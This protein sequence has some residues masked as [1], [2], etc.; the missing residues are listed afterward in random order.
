M[1][2]RGGDGAGVVEQVNR[3][4]KG[5]VGFFAA[6]KARG[7]EEDYGV[8]NAFAAETR[9]RLGVFSKDTDQAAVG[10]VE[11]GRILIGQRGAVERF[12]LWMA[13]GF[14]GRRVGGWVS[15]FVSH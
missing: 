4:I 12:R 11:K 7:T 5:A 13:G 8:L 1:L 15:R 3:S 6:V 14:G 9:Q 2:G 10:A